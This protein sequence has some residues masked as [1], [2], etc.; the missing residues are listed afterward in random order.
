MGLLSRP[1]VA[2]IGRCSV[3][4]VKRME[5]GRLQDAVIKVGKRTLYDS[6]KVAAALGVSWDLLAE[7]VPL[8]RAGAGCPAVPSESVE[9][10]V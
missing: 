9:S 8:V 4:T 2:V 6:E 3:D 10:T 1:E 7:V 5:A